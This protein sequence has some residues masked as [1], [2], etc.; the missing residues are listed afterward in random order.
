MTELQREANRDF[1]PTTANIMH[2]VYGACIVERGV[3]SY[4]CMKFCKALQKSMEAK[5]DEKF[6]QMKRRDYM[7]SLAGREIKGPV[8]LKG[9]EEREVRKG[10]KGWISDVAEK[11]TGIAKSNL[12]GHSAEDMA[13]QKE[14]TEDDGSCMFDDGRAS[15]SD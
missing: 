3:G 10:I 15:V 5:A 13:E 14:Q 1:T 4:N 9:K 6:I 11:F 8:T 2:A 7:Q 12:N